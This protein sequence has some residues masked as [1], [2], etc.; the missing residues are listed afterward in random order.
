MSTAARATPFILS[1]FFL[2][3]RGEEVK[4]S[5]RRRGG[6]RKKEGRTISLFPSSLTSSRPALPSRW[7]AFSPHWRARLKKG[8]PLR[9]A[10]GAWRRWPGRWQ[11]GGERKRKRWLRRG[12]HRWRRRRRRSRCFES[13]AISPLRRCPATAFSSLPS[14]SLRVDAGRRIAHRGRERKNGVP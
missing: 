12:R 8:K 9:P 1:E 3:W 11:G 14:S 6:R 13:K 10:P 4:V 7:S 2:V 5:N